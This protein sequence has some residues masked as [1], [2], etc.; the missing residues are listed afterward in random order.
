M[1]KR[2]TRFEPGL[3]LARHKELGEYLGGKFITPINIEISPSGVCDAICPW[4]FYRQEQSTIRKVLD[5]NLFREARMEGL[6]EELAGM[7]VK[8]ISWTGGGEPTLHPSFPKFV[9]LAHWAGL[10]QGLFTNGLKKPEYDPTSFEWIRVSKTN[11]PWNEENL[12]ILRKC[13]TLGLCINYRGQEDDEIVIEALKTAEKLEFLKESPNHA[14]YVQVRPALKTLGDKTI[15]DTPKIEHP[16]LKITSY[17]FLGSG[18]ERNYDQCEAFHFAPFIWHDGDVD[19]CGYHRKNSMFNLGNVY[20]K[21]E[22]GRFKSIMK[23]APQKVQV[24]DSCQICCKLNAM[25]SMIN[26]MKSLEDIDFP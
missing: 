7:G 22:E 14:T 24:I 12:K 13:K 20:N 10:K 26:M 18:S 15:V 17:K 2:E 21:G 3:K 11:F 19:I 1:E 16:L 6:I 23:N 5:G 8:S 4:C 25:N 9:Q